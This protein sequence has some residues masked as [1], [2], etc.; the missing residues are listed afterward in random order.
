[1][2][3]YLLDQLKNSGASKENVLESFDEKY[4][5]F[6]DVYVPK[7]IQGAT[8]PTVS[9]CLFMPEDELRSY[10]STIGR[11]L[12]GGPYNEK[13]EKLFEVHKEL[14][15]QFAGEEE[16]KRRKPE[17]FTRQELASLLGGLRS[18]GLKEEWLLSNIRPHDFL[19][20]KKVSNQQIDEL[21]QHYK[22]IFDNF[23]TIFR[24]GE[25]YDFCYSNDDYNRYYWI[26]IQDAF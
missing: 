17:E 2:V 5:L 1:M 4:K 20:E 22:K 25:T 21:I 19:D 11:L 3:Q 6:A 18:S 16:L 10:Q 9:Y 8:H 15:A 14:I 26:P 7:Q 23:N 13:R 24:L 12:V